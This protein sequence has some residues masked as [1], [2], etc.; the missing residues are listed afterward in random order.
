[1]SHVL[2]VTIHV[3]RESIE[4]FRAASLVNANAS[5]AEPGCLQFDVNQNQEDPT[6]FML[7]EVYR[8]VAALDFHRQQPH[9]HAWHATVTDMMAQPRSRT[10]YNR[11]EA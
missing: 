5:R 10:V 6:Q 1:M 9:Y 2:S 3:K 8:D 11:C 4:L 7:Y